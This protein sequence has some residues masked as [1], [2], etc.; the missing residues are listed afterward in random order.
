[1]SFSYL[2][3]FLGD[4]K[5]LT[6]VSLL[7]YTLVL[8]LNSFAPK[9]TLECN[10]S[11]I[12]TFTNVANWGETVILNKWQ[13][14]RMDLFLNKEGKQNL[15]IPHEEEK[16]TQINTAQSARTGILKKGVP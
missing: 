9:T 14:Q 16:G 12:F 5:N 13:S 3:S 7:G 4:P 11:S 1:M 6:Q 8:E 15:I 10:L 2:P